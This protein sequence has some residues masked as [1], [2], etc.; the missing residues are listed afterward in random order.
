[1]I[2]HQKSKSVVKNRKKHIKFRTNLEYHD[3]SLG[4][5]SVFMGVPMLSIRCL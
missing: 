2:V 3:F 5:P 4:F 1:M